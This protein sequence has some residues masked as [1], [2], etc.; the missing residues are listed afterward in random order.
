MVSFWAVSMPTVIA[1]T[2]MRVKIFFI[3]FIFS[4]P[5]RYKKRGQGIG[6]RVQVFGFGFNGYS[7]L[8][9]SQIFYYLCCREGR[10][11]ITVISTDTSNCKCFF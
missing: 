6:I 9:A 5:Q 1:V 8:G 4:E 3:V 2:R 10:D 7:I 11:V